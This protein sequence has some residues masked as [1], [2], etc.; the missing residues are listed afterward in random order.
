[1][2]LVLAMV[3]SPF[4]EL[5]IGP[6]GVTEV[7]MVKLLLFVISQK[8]T[9]I[10]FQD[11]HKFIFTK[12][13]LLFLLISTLGLLYNYVIKGHISGDSRSMLFDLLVYFFVTLSVF[14]LEIV[15]TNLDSN[16]IWKIIKNIYVIT[17]IIVFF[18]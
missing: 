8:H 6:L 16:T 9:L 10:N 5:R 3:L 2:L 4:T 14:T 13:W 18:Y 12:Y 7:S 17:S 1:M 15:L 11:R